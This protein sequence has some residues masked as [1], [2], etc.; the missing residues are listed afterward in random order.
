MR[1]GILELLVGESLDGWVEVGKWRM[2]DTWRRCQ[3]GERIDRWG[4]EVTKRQKKN[5]R[6]AK[7][8]GENYRARYKSR[9]AV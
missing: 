5:D 9:K 2:V 3:I 7:P 6:L 8:S 1:S 4:E